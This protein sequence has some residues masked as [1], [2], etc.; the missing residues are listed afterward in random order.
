L[1]KRVINSSGECHDTALNSL[2]L[3]RGMTLALIMRQ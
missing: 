3:A 2:V 1:L